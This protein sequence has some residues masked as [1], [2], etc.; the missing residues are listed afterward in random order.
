MLRCGSLEALVVVRDP[1]ANKFCVCIRGRQEGVESYAT[2]HQTLLISRVLEHAHNS[3]SYRGNTRD[4]RSNYIC[5]HMFKLCVN[6]TD[7]SRLN[8]DMCEHK[9]FATREKEKNSSRATA[10]RNPDK[11]MLVFQT[12]KNF[13]MIYRKF[14]SLWDESSAFQSAIRCHQDLRESVDKRWWWWWWWWIYLQWDW[15]AA[16]WNM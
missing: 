9:R 6:T 2:R 3:P 12:L 13:M 7:S 1:S 14:K 15:N 11:L 16:A 10:Y 8:V 5:M 4:T